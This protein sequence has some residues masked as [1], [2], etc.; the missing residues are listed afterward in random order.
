MD[1]ASPNVALA[2]E[3]IGHMFA[4]AQARF[5]PATCKTTGCEAAIRSITDEDV[6]CWNDG[7]QV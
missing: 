2:E 5:N 6:A 4:C 3:V 7:L 1:A